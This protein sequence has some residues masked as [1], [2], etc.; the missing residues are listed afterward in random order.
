MVRKLHQCV[1]CGKHLSSY[2]CLWRHKKTCKGGD[3]HTGSGLLYSTSTNR[4]QVNH[5]GETS[6]DFVRDSK[7]LDSTE[8]ANGSTGGDNCVDD[9]IDNAFSRRVKRKYPTM[10]RKKRRLLTVPPSITNKFDINDG[11][12]GPSTLSCQSLLCCRKAR[13]RDGNP[14]RHLCSTNTSE[15]QVNR[16]G[17]T[18]SDFVRD[19][20]IS[21]SVEIE[22]GSTGG[23]HCVGYTTDDSSSAE[24][25]F[26]EFGDDVSTD[27]D[28]EN[29]SSGEESLDDDDDGFNPFRATHLYKKMK[30][31]MEVYLPKAVKEISERITMKK[32]DG[33][34][35]YL[36]S[37]GYSNTR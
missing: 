5:V 31:D 6:G 21:D 9:T 36:N 13:R 32:R 35:M 25:D 34:G 20:K 14:S 2:K 3:N 12:D 29:D 26:E 23:D 15:S 10:Q 30:R 28:V 19:N 27:E 17:E 8:M 4:P 22:S 37:W 33:H 24:I 1:R 7:K 16:A 18:S 11:D